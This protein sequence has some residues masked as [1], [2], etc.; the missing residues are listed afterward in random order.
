MNDG[1]MQRIDDR[2]VR[3]LIFVGDIVNRGLRS[4]ATCARPAHSLGDR[5]RIVL[6]NHD[7]P[8]AGAGHSQP[9]KSD[10]PDEILAST[11]RP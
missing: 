10:T 5:A 9:Y 6:G 2:A 7:L 4:L 1:L 11:R 8:F 3:K